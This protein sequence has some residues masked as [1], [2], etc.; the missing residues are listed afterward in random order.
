MAIIDEDDLIDPKI[1]EE[2]KQIVIRQLEQSG[3]QIPQQPEEPNPI[4]AREAPV[5]MQAEILDAF[6]AEMNA[7]REFVEGVEAAATP[8]ARDIMLNL[9]RQMQTGRYGIKVDTSPMAPTM[10]MIRNVEIRELNAALLEGGQ[11]GISRKQM[12]EASDV[13][14]KDE[15]IADVPVVAQEVA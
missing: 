8:I 13:Q 1:F 9:I 7:F 11:P 6:Q 4:R 14:N 3:A 10:R 15:I 5:S 12:V 2:A